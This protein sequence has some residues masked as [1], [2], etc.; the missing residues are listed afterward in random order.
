MELKRRIV[1]IALGA[2]L[3]LIII[4]VA[5]SC[6]SFGKL[7]SGERLDRIEDSPYYIDGSFRYPGAL[8][9]RP[10]PPEETG[11]KKKSGGMFNAIWRIMFG[12]K[13]R[14]KPAAPL[15]SSKTDLFS[16]DPNDNLIV[17]MGHSSYYMQV[18]GKRFLVDPV[19]SGKALVVKAFKGSDVYKPE[20]IPPLDFLV[21]SHDHWD[22]L[23]YKT[24]KALKEKTAKVITGL[25]T[26]SHLEYWGFKNE[27]IVELEWNES[28]DLGGGFSTTAIATPH[29]SGRALKRNKTQ[30]SA[31]VLETPNRTIYIGGDGGYASFFADVGMR[32]GPFD[33]AI[34]ECGQYNEQWRNSHMFPEDTAQASIDLKANKLFAVHYAKFILSTHSWDE[35]ITRLRAVCDER[36]I[37]LIHPLIGSQANFDE[38]EIYPRW[39]EGIE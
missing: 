8:P 10:E 22:H 27:N 36:G 20:D 7:P 28:A 2:I 37:T 17:W 3:A 23:D 33:L 5:S 19:F 15:P 26:A 31:F 29:F 39:W 14:E 1:C 38:D 30:W 25:G 24:V 6:R 13:N 34:L 32:Y 11:K 12:G 9:V 18:D 4:A 35:P 16:L 21:I